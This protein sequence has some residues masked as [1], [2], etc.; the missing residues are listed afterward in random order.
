MKNPQKSLISA[1]GD[2]AF[3]PLQKVKLQPVHSIKQYYIKE[4][5]IKVDNLF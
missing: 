4:R 3:V 5:E 1:G 2:F